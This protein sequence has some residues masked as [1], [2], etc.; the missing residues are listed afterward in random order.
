[1]SKHVE[2]DWVEKGAKI[3]G[4]LFVL[5][6]LLAFFPGWKMVGGLLENKDI[7][8]WAQ[9]A[10][11]IVGI[12]IAIAVPAW[13]RKEE[14]RRKKESDEEKKRERDEARFSMVLACERFLGVAGNS[15]EIIEKYLKSS[16]NS[17]SIKVAASGLKE[18][19]EMAKALDEKLIDPLAAI[20]ILSMR[21]I[22]AQL[23][24]VVDEAFGEDFKNFSMLDNQ[25]AF[26]NERVK[27]IISEWKKWKVK[28]YSQNG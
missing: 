21:S 12:F 11:A 22:C 18:A 25:I 8:A 24:V 3:V 16:R 2:D 1:M 23:L 14:M 7:P 17:L 6:G 13:Q 20:H 27:D 26:Y 28:R 9:A 5:F 15:V 19:L 4:V 10:G